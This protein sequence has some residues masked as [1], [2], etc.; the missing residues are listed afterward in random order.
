MESNTALVSPLP[1]DFALLDDAL[2][3]AHQNSLP[4]SDTR[5]SDFDLSLPLHDG[6]AL[7]VIPQKFNPHSFFVPSLSATDGIHSDFSPER[8]FSLTSADGDSQ[9]ADDSSTL[10]LHATRGDVTRL[11]PPE[12]PALRPNV[13]HTRRCRAKVNTNFERLLQVLPDPSS[14]IEVKHKAQVLQYAID[15]YKHVSCKNRMLEMKL[16]LRS[17]SEM[18]RWVQSVVSASP[19]LK[20]TLKSFIAM[21]CLTKNWKY[22]ELWAP[23]TRAGSS[24]VSLRYVAGALPPTVG[25]EALHRLRKYRA[26]SRKY[27]F[28]PRCGVP[29]RVFLTMRPEWLPLLNDPVAFPRAPHAVRNQVQVTFAVPVIVNGAVEMVVEFFDT[30]R[31]DYDPATLNMANDIAAM[32]GKAFTEKDTSRCASQFW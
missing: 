28:P 11:A 31:R 15:Y 6:S 26:R 18:Y 14:G 22:A 10:H 7:F 1:P 5:A 16:A 19:N 9:S 17:P 3:L 27:K 4:P 13:S 25:G 21:I 30:E 24:S 20:E 12:P 23:Q 32:F 8:L 2:L 29:G